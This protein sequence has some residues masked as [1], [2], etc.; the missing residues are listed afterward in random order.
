MQTQ[1]KNNANYVDALETE[2][3]YAVV[4]KRGRIQLLLQPT[5]KQLRKR[6]KRGWRL[7]STVD[8][9][10]PD[11]KPILTVTIQGAIQEMENT[12]ARAENNGKK[13]KPVKAD[14]E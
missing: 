11:A 6:G 12:G 8:H 14:S 13:R 1:A 2:H 5:I 4:T 7:L 10:F 9:G 3:L